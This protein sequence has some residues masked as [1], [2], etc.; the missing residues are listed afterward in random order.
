MALFVVAVF[1]FK[2]N[3]FIKPLQPALIIISRRP[4]HCA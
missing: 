4:V 1:E 3:N 2:V